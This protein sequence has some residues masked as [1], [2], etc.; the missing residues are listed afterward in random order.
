MP[1]YGATDLLTPCSGH[2]MVDVLPSNQSEEG[3]QQVNSVLSATRSWFS[4]SHWQTNTSDDATLVPNEQNTSIAPKN[5]GLLIKL[6]LLDKRVARAIAFLIT[7]CFAVA[8]FLAWQSSR[9]TAS[10]PQPARV[11]ASP[12]LERQLEAMS[13]GLTALRQSVDQLAASLEQM[14]NDITN[15]HT[16]QQA[17][18]DKVSEPPPPRPVAA[19]TSKPTPR[20]SQPV[21]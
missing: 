7:F 2:T 3:T 10:A 13:L 16:A 19:P 4:G 12:N 17:I 11:A 20:P 9:E 1:T 18:F 15:L 6:S 8:A 21:R 5:N 14:R